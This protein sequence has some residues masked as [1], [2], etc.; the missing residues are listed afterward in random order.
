MC[1]GPGVGVY[2]PCFRSSRGCVVEQSE[3]RGQRTDGGMMAP[4]EEGHVL[5]HRDK[6]ENGWYGASGSAALQ[7]PSDPLNTGLH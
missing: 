4:E 5:R 6:D 7:G 3:G 2:L 1:K